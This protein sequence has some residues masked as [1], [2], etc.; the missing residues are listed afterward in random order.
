LGGLGNDAYLVDDPDDQVIEL[1]SAGLD[2]VRG[3]I[4]CALPANVENLVPRA[5]GPEARRHPI[6]PQ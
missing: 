5:A 1:A 4:S 6:W 2:A 3:A